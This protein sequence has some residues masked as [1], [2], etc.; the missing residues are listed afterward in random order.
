MDERDTR[1]FAAWWVRGRESHAH[2]NAHGTD[3]R[4]VSTN[5]HLKNVIDSMRRT[6]M[7]CRCTGA[8]RVGSLGTRVEGSALPRRDRDNGR[9][10]SLIFCSRSLHIPTQRGALHAGT[11]VVVARSTLK[12]GHFVGCRGTQPPRENRACA[13]RASLASKPRALLSTSSLRAALGCR[14][15]RR[16]R[17]H[18]RRFRRR[19]GGVT[20]TLRAN[21]GGARAT[22]PTHRWRLTRVGRRFLHSTARH[23]NFGVDGGRGA[24]SAPALALAHGAAMVRC[25]RRS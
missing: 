25:G 5:P 3:C 1:A 13:R 23:G 8:R 24:P 12:M 11:S 21:Q 6:Q 20:T 22:C 14:R 19:S 7:A 18:P 17:S 4:I 2:A 15:G 10:Y 9:Q 16:G